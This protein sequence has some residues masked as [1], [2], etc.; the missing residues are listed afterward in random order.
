MVGTP[1][2]TAIV[3]AV[4]VALAFGGGFA[5][6]DWRATMQI[7]RLHN[8]N[9]LLSAANDRCATDIE[10]VRFALDAQKAAA[11]R[12]EKEAIRAMREAGKVAAAHTAKAR[13]I[14]ALPPVADVSADGQCEAI[15]REQQEYVQDRRRHGA[16]Q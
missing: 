9:A 14:R 13:A 10:S 8:D 5:L 12:R 7:Q 1:A 6:G 11:V 3:I 2:V 16:S 15:F 4:L